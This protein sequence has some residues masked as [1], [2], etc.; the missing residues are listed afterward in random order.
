MLIQDTCYWQRL[1]CYLNVFPKNQI[2]V[3]LLEDLVK[4]HISVLA[5][6]FEF[7][8]VDSGFAAK[9][10]LRKF[11]AGE[12][13]RYDSGMLRR[14]RTHP[15]WGY[16]IARLSPEFQERIFVPLGLRPL[17]RKP[18]EIDAAARRIHQE[19]IAPDALKLLE[20]CGKPP[21]YWGE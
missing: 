20:F 12:Y 11:N 4:D 16:K 8:G 14:L 17:F 15:F 10:E 18:I 2:K 3:I 21:N 19:V 9:I 6:C 1:S 13:K 5:D 7:I